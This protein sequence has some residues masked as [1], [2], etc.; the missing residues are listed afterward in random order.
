MGLDIGGTKTHGVRWRQGRVVAEARAGSANVQNVSVEAAGRNLAELFARLGG[1]PVSAVIAGSG[2]VDTDDDA[3]RLRALIELH[4]QTASV[5][6]VHDTRL[7]LAAGRAPVGTGVIAGTGSVAWGITADGREARSGG[8]G[9]LLGD[10]GSGYWMGREA[11]RQTLRG[12]NLGQEPGELA[13]R[14]LAANQVDSPTELIGL[15]HGDTGRR[16]W[17][18]QAGL[19][20][21]AFG[22]GDAESGRII[23]SAARHISALVEDVAEVLKVVQP[24]IIGGGL[25]MNQPVLQ[26]RI[27]AR[28]SGAGHQD[29][30][31]LA[32]EPVMGTE[33]L[34]HHGT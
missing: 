16:Y 30:R 26:E 8:W 24:V 25:A 23:D 1:G 3:A 29:V 6:V 27:R 20:F 19:V 2:G 21:E 11:V 7:I 9:Y 33:Y 28:L 17:A 4:A 13:R 12:F 14:V 15:F 34:L 22:A 32:V 10:E 5:R 31:F 18:A